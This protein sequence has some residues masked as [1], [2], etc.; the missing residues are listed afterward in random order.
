MKGIWELC[1]IFATLLQVWNCYK[2]VF[3]K[4]KN[5]LGSIENLISVFC[6]FK[7]KIKLCL[8]HFQDIVHFYDKTQQEP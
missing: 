7:T 8:G 5:T 3:K 6:F 1:T 4:E 2:M